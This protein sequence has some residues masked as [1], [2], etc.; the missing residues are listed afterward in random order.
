MADLTSTLTITGTVN[1]RAVSIT[2]AFTLEDVYD[3][4]VVDDQETGQTH[5]APGGGGALTMFNQ[6]NP[7]Y[8][9]A[10]NRDA[11]GCTQERISAGG[12]DHNFNLSPG[13]LFCLTA[14]EGTG[15]VL[16]TS[17]ATSIALDDVTA[18]ELQPIITS[19]GGLMQYGRINSLSAYQATT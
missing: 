6:N 7:N 4:G 13:Q 9:M 5:V 8:L 2:H 18:V 11:C 16:S 15:M 12:N 17:S 14:A 1:G 10:A 3:A 19:T